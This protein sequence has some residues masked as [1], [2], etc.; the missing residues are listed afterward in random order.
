MKRKRVKEG[1]RKML[2]LIAIFIACIA[3][4]VTIGV[5]SWQYNIAEVREI[6]MSFAVEGIAGI[7]TD[8]DAIYFGSAPRG[9]SGVRKIHIQ[10]DEDRLVTAVALGNIS[11]VVTISDNNFRVGP[12]I[13]KTLELVATAPIDDPYITE[14]KGTLRLIFRRI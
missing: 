3:A 13:R 14:Y 8:T 2:L 6:P 11:S 9:S 1:K 4:G 5:S 7:N 10:S 12:G